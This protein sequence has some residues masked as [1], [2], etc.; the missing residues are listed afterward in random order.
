MSL[1]APWVVGE[2]VDWYYWV[3]VVGCECG[4]WCGGVDSVSYSVVNCVFAV[5]VLVLYFVQIWY[6]IIGPSS[7]CG[8]FAEPWSEGAHELVFVVADRLQETAPYTPNRFVWAF[9]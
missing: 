8:E 1:P 4:R 3:G 6:V 2:C 9:L 5:G 7:S